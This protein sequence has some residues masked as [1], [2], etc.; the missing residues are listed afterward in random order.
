MRSWLSS[1][2]MERN[3]SAG[4]KPTEGSSKGC[5]DWPETLM[6]VELPRAPE[7]MLFDEGL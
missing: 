6:Q 5:S 7:S 3:G 2:I 1:Y 4:F